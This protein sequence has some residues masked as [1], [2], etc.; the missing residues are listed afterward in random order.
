M[1]IFGGLE[2]DATATILYAW[3]WWVNNKWCILMK[4]ADPITPVYS[5][6]GY[7]NIGICF[8]WVGLWK[9]HKW[10]PLIPASSWPP[11]GPFSWSTEATL[12]ITATGLWV[13]P[14]RIST[15]QKRKKRQ[16]S[17]M[18]S[19]DLFLQSNLASLVSER[20]KRQISDMSST[21]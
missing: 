5:Y 14:I 7:K 19:V 4:V 16:I 2:E 10:L 6:T 8:F 9:K 3:F 20:K 21:F 1:L 11:L 18:W 15:Y 13:T 12:H 17:D